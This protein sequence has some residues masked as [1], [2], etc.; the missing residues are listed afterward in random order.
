MNGTGDLKD[1]VLQCKLDSQRWFPDTWNDDT[2]LL[3]QAVA[4]A[5][6][7]GELCNLVKKVQRGTLSLEEARA[8]LGEE[9]I[10]VLIYLCNIFALLEVDPVKIYAIKRRRNEARFGDGRRVAGSATAV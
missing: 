10:D 8:E 2:S 1:L 4:L 3:Y 9:A 7:V 6:E 5:G